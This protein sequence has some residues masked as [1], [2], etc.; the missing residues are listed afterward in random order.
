VTA[1]AI[2]H[3]LAPLTLNLEQP[4]EGDDLDH[5]RGQSRPCVIRT[6]MNLNSGFGGVNACLLLGRHLQ[7]ARGWRGGSSGLELS[8]A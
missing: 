3:Q 2:Y 4:E 5:V 8:D 1:L 6:A 7:T